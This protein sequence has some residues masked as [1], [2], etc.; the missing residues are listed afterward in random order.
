MEKPIALAGVMGSKESGVTEKTT[1]VVLE[2]A[3]FDPEVVRVFI[4]VLKKRGEL[5]E[6]TYNKARLDEILQTT[7]SL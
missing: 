6:N 7:N 4:E 5:Q 1:R 2:S 3:Y